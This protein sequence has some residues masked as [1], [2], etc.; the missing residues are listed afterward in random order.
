MMCRERA[1]RGPVYEKRGRDLTWTTHG[2]SHKVVVPY[3]PCGISVR[4]LCWYRRRGHTSNENVSFQK[5]LCYGQ[6]TNS[7]VA[8]AC[9]NSRIHTFHAIVCQS[10]ALSV[11]SLQAKKYSRITLNKI[12]SVLKKENE[13]RIL[14]NHCTC[15]S[16]HVFHRLSTCGTGASSPAIYPYVRD[17]FPVAPLGYTTVLFTVHEYTTTSSHLIRTPHI[18]TCAQFS[19]RF[20]RALHFPHPSFVD[21]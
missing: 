20:F 14:P 5:P 16:P 11:H 13:K 12:E 10:K 6:W 17:S 8:I 2:P 1:G 4:F 15:P 7:E 9:M 18:C 19:F 21:P 3:C